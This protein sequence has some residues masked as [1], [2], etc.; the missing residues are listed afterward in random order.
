[1]KLLVSISAGGASG[2]GGGGEW[3]WVWSRRRPLH[4]QTCRLRDFV[5]DHSLRERDV[6]RVAA[7]GEHALVGARQKLAAAGQ[8]HAHTRHLLQ[9]LQRAPALPHNHPHVLIRH[10]QN[11]L[12]GA[13]VPRHLHVRTTAA[14]AA[15]VP[16]R[17]RHVHGVGV[18]RWGRGSSGT[19][20]GP[21]ARHG[22]H[23]VVVHA[24]VRQRVLHGHRVRV[25]VRVLCHFGENER[26]GAQLLLQL[27][28]QRDHALRHPREL[29]LLVAQRDPR[30]AVLDKVP[31]VGAPLADDTTTRLRGD[32]HP[33]RKRLLCV[34]SHRAAARRR[35]LRRGVR[36]QLGKHE[37]QR[38]EDVADAARGE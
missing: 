23:G 12:Q 35:L 11:F 34:H 3:W 20:P 22:V 8:R 28:H 18:V 14:A 31:H 36:V 6:L 16:S 2:G 21:N 30:A 9:L 15:H 29:L 26:R 38:G 37:V 5:L 7:D 17:L 13:A 4:R 1:M 24:G 25:V 33:Q 32:N 19:T 27:P 10:A